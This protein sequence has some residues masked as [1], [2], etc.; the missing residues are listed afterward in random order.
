M[1]RFIF[2]SRKKKEVKPIDFTFG[3]QKYHYEEITSTQPW[4][5]I[6]YSTL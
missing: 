3:L 1:S 6:K 5:K 4:K 2:N